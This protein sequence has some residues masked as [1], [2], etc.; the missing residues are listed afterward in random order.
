MKETQKGVVLCTSS[1]SSSAKAQPSFF[2]RWQ[3]PTPRGKLIASIPEFARLEYPSLHATVLYGDA[4]KTAGGSR[5][6]ERS[7]HQIARHAEGAIPMSVGHLE[8]RSLL[9]LLTVTT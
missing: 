7:E 3:V 5:E 1:H 2:S 8:V 9:L 6:L 4:K